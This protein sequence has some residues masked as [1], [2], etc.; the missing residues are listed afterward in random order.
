[1]QTYSN[2]FARVFKCLLVLV[3]LCECSSVYGKVH[4]R[5]RN[6]IRPGVGLNFRVQSRDDDL[7]YHTL[8]YGEEYEFKFIANFWDTTLFFCSANWWDSTAK[9]RIQGSFDIYKNSKD[10]HICWENCTRLARPDGVY[11]N[12]Y[13]DVADLYMMYEWPRQIY[14]NQQNQTIA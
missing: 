3:A 10:R 6:E 9:V 5:L 11:G 2:G 8:S 1:M 14:P 13:G 4:V 12:Y 7:G